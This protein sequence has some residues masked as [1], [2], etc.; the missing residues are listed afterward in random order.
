VR[1]PTFSGR[2]ARLGS[3]AA[4]LL[5]FASIALAD[6]G[7]K[8]IA[9]GAEVYGPVTPHLTQR[10]SE[11]PPSRAWQP[12]DPIREVPRRIYP[13]LGGPTEPS[14][15]GD[16]DP[17]LQIQRHSRAPSLIVDLNFAGSGFG[18]G[19]PPDTVGDVGPDHYVQAVNSTTIRIFDKAGTLVAGPFR[20]DTLAPPADACASGSGDP[21]VL[22]DRLADRWFLQE[23]RTGANRLC[24][25]ISQTSDPTGAYYFYGFSSPTFPDYP[26]F[27]VW[28]D[29]YYGGT[30]ESGATAPVYA[31][32]RSNMLA[33]NPATMQRLTVV[34][35][36]SG[37]GFQALTPADLDG[38]TPPPIGVGGIFMRHFDGEAHGSPDPANDLLHMFEMNVDW[39]TPANTTISTLPSITIADFNA[40]MVNYSTFYSVPQPG[41]TQRLDPIR[42]AILNRLVY[43]NFGSHE[44]LLGNFATNRDPAVSG[45]VVSAGIRWF[46]LRRVGG[47]GNPW[48]LHQEGTFGGDSNS[49]TAQ[50]FMGG[51]AMDGAGN[52]GLG[53]SKT[54]TSPAIFPSIG[55]T[56]R[57]ATDT[58]GTMGPETTVVS[59]VQ[60][61]TS[62]GRWGDYANMSID[63]VDDCT[64]WYTNEYMP[65]SSWGTRIVSFVFEEC[66]VGFDIAATPTALEACALSDPDPT[67]SLDITSTGGWAHDV[68]LVATGLPPG[69]TASFSL[70]DQA[71]DFSTVLT[72]EDIHL[73][74]SGS[75]PIQ[76]TGTGSDDPATIRT[77]QVLLNLVLAGPDVP[78]LLDPPDAAGGVHIRP[79]LSWSAADEATSYLLEIATDAGFSDVVYSATVSG[80]SHTP[81]SSLDPVSTYYW[82]VTA[83][84]LCGN[85]PSAARS[86]VTAAVIVSCA[87][88]P[89]SDVP[90]RI[91]PGSATQGVTDSILTIGAGQGGS[92]V[93]VNVLNLAGTHTWINDLSFDLIS[94]AATQVRVMARSCGSQDHF[95]LNLDDEAAPGA[96]PCPPTTG[97]T[98][99]PS[100]PLSGFD[101]ENSAG[102]WTL[103]V[104]DHEAGDIGELQSWSLEI[105]AEAIAG[106]VAVNDAYAVDQDSTLTVP[107]PGVLGNDFGTGLIAS[108]VNDVSDGVLALAAD[109]G[110]DYEPDPGFCGSDS[111]VYEAGDG[112]EADQATVTIT[113]NCINTAPS[114]ADQDFAVDE[115][116]PNGTVVGTIVASDPDA[117]DTLEFSVTGGSGD[118]AFAVD[119]ATGQI[120][121][122]DSSQL[123]FETTASFTLEVTVTDS[124]SLS[125]AATITIALSDV[126]EAP[127]IADQQFAIDENS[128]NGAVVGTLVA[129]DPDGGDVL[130]FGVTGGSGAGAFAVDAA[131]GQIT[132]TDASQLDF[133]TTPSFTLEVTVTDA[134]GLSDDAT[135]TIEINDVNEA[136]V[137]GALADQAATE[138]LFF[139]ID[140]SAAFSDPDGDTLSF[141]ATGL[142]ASLAIDPATGVISGTPTFGD[143]GNHAITV[144]ASDGT[145]TVE[146]GFELVIEAFVAGIFR[147]GFEA[148]D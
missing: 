33:G 89:S 140:V 90:L 16:P 4:L 116:S 37:F 83:G 11:L 142:P 109:G 99:R 54:D 64:F 130:S 57:L 80:T 85:Q 145:L 105:C 117:G 126:N 88:F 2:A 41:T 25:Y 21:I 34:P 100:N 67:F 106:V 118:T 58:P 53:Y 138:G 6:D 110:F 146:A 135:I 72:V 15:K 48:T 87:V 18:G 63:P 65:G 45:S 8:V 60:S 44:T 10:A 104:T 71:P 56:G 40:W 19:T 101:G 131:S 51:I 14:G 124:G 24:I 22:Y 13:L 147:D 23:F 102:T 69:T 121:V 75:Y 35:K 61:Q 20:L 29:A 49:P 141:S 70:N 139:S 144:T 128:A 79:E 133:E 96:W 111:F 47:P 31:F 98:Y 43:R 112:T 12:G 55:V 68:N 52:I 17:L 125:D 97:L 81:T 82:R 59:G 46:E 66:M 103:R 92:I 122:A 143:I 7:R 36:L 26:H 62:S 39:A 127:S 74:N 107:S 120:T 113:V 91:P 86:F 73:S 137:A 148:D 84:N 119:T 28:P 114:I 50:F 95:N 129:T 78:V 123:D 134:G 38:A 27:G 136:P 132:V 32:D 108:L 115:N 42:E 94:P 9:R 5:L 93:D 1:K 76:V 77:R 30:N 3:V